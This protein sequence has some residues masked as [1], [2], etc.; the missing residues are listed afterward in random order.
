MLNTDFA[1]QFYP[2]NLF[3][4]LSSSLFSSAGGF[5]KG[6]PFNLQDTVE[7]Q[8]QNWQTVSEAQQIILKGLQTVTRQQ[9][10]IVSSL[11]ENQSNMINLF[12]Q[13]GTPEEKIALHSDLARKQYKTAIE[14]MRDLQNTITDTLRHASDILHQRTLRNLSEA[15]RA[16]KHALI[17]ANADQITERK[18]AA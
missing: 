1:S 17:P 18:I 9:T 12:I 16:S 2:K 4:L 6:L 3:S 5:P 15:H 10:D 14:N 7:M 13:A 8:R 11:I